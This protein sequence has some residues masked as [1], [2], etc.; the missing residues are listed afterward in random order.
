MVGCISFKGFRLAIPTVQGRAADATPFLH[1]H[2]LMDDVYPQCL[3]NITQE[4]YFPVLDWF[5][6]LPSRS[7]RKFQLILLA[8][9]FQ[10]THLS[11][12]AFLWESRLQ[13]YSRNQPKT[14]LFRCHNSPIK[15][16][17]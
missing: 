9:M 8:K 7:M 2:Q 17:S 12:P 11:T 10:L 3:G 13:T 16:S 6:T 15:L 4:I 14:D 1:Q 5:G